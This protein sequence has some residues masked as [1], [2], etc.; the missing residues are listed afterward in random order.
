MEKNIK[1]LL[2]KP[3]DDVKTPFTIDDKGAFAEYV[4]Q[5]PDDLPDHLAIGAS[6]II[7]D[8]KKTVEGLKKYWISGRIVGMK[9]IS[10][11]NPERENMLY[12]EDET[13]NPFNILED[14]PGGPHNHQPMVLKIELDQELEKNG[15]SLSYF[16]SPIQRPP[17]ALSRLFLPKMK[18]NGD[19]HPSLTTILDIKTSGLAIGCVGSGNTPLRDDS[20]FLT[21][22]LDVTDLENKHAFIVGES[23][24]GKTV[25]LKNLAYEIRKTKDSNFDNRVIMIDVQ[26]D[27]VQLLLPNLDDIILKPRI[28]W[29]ETYNNSNE[30]NDITSESV[31]K[32]LAPLQLIIPKSNSGIL[33]Q[34]LSSLKLLCRKEGINVEEISLRLQDLGTPSDVEYLFNVSSPQVPLLLDGLADWLK[35]QKR[36]VAIEN[37]KHLLKKGKTKVKGNGQILSEFGVSFYESTYDAAERALESLSRYFDYD[38]DAIK[39]DKSPLELLNQKGTTIIYLADLNL[40]ERIMWEMQIV[41]WLNDNNDKINFSTADVQSGETYVFFDEAH[42]IIPA[43]PIGIADKE[44]FDRL[45][46]NFERLA[47]EGRKFGINLILSTQSPKDLHEIVPEQC[48]NRVVM[49]INPRN[50]A[51]AYLDPE[52]AIVASRFNYGQFWFQSPFNGTPYWIRIHSPATPIPHESVKKFWPKVR[53]AAKALK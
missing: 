6:V 45:R 47:R 48:P 14:L 1:R 18:D 33:S 9:S 16:V 5:H 28:A 34:N 3:Y 40:E 32:T 51:Y 29:Q 53:A 10:P 26:G 12:Q 35:G 37:L 24:S 11:F 43:K 2:A 8:V 20:N 44:T 39:D 27:I 21:Y 50:A 15:K 4:I 52:L 25:F 31:Q 46:A 19:E 38:E 13:E 41:K 7:A 30:R 17:S 36:K 22:K 42:Q 23:G 49:K